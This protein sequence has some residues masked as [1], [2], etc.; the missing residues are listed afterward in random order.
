MTL[1]AERFRE[2]R[3]LFET[4]LDLEPAAWPGFVRSATAHDPSLGDEVLAL[5]HADTADAG[6]E[7]L[8]DGD[9]GTAFLP[10]DLAGRRVGGFQILRR[11]GSGG[12]GTVYEAQQERPQ[13]RVALK[14]LSVAFRS[15]RAQRRFEDEVDILARLQHPAIAQVLEVGTVAVGGTRMPWFA[16]ELVQ[17]P[18][19]LDRFV[20]DERLDGERIAALFATVCDAVH[21]AHQRGV[22]HRDLKPQN[23]LVDRHGQP[24]IIDFGIARITGDGGRRTE[25]RT[26]EILGTLAYMSPERL[27]SGAAA[28]DVPADVW[29]LGVILYELLAGRPPFPLEGLPPAKA[30]DVL[31]TFEPLPPSRLDAGVP[32]ELDWIVQKAMARAAAE[33]Y[34]SAAELAAD[35]R[36]LDRDEPLQAGPQSATYR[37]KKLARRHR[38]ALSAAAVVLTA[39]VA[40]LVIAA[41]GWRRVALAELVARQEAATLA[42]V[43]RFQERILRGAYGEPAGRD[44]RLADVVDA[45]AADLER[46]PF[47]EPRV[48][49]GL[50]NAVGTS[51]LGLGLV[52]EAEHQFLKARSVAD[53]AQIPATDAISIALGNN[54]GLCFEEQGKL[55]QAEAELSATLAARIER[56][57]DGDAET[58]ISRHNLASLQVKLGR[59][60]DALASARS[61]WEMFA[62]RQGEHAEATISARSTMGMALSALG[63]FDEA[64][65]AFDGAL[66]AAQAHLP[67]DHPA[68]LSVQNERANHSRRRGRFEEYVAAMAEI[69]AVRERT[70]GPAHP[71]TLTALNNLAVGHQDRGDF[72]AAEATLRRIAAARTAAGITGGFEVVGTGQNLTVAIRKQGRTVEAEAH[73]RTVRELAAA[74]LPADHWLLG[75][76]TKELGA[77]LRELGRHEEAEVLL[78]EAARRLETAVGI[79]DFR[80]QKVVAELVQ[81]YEAWQR[82]QAAAQWAARRTPG[83]AR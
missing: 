35:L 7:P 9:P 55:D 75:V 18:R 40:G 80:T 41:A 6:A 29:A 63:R 16:M 78:L 46:Q 43:N 8:L 3:R 48:E 45:A 30:V 39:L 57:G 47:A 67:P 36:R 79:A 50:R 2:V 65:A 23:V 72:A 12:M 32:R 70:L 13:R 73:A 5:L 25:T 76:V 74:T 26:G 51:Y 14:T 49:V 54:L 17:E 31:R 59:P 44:V 38:L 34:A 69:A 19:P 68:T 21:Y 15:E 10:P 33:R 1:R 28:D 83:E 61:A 58:A 52:G 42:A 24:K 60:A 37:L 77:C 64:D 56:Y 82:P 11:I 22:L 53:R 62:E 66:A 81:L 71:R 4:A 20:R 27:E